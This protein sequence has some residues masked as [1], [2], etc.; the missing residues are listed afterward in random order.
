[1]ENTQCGCFGKHYANG[2]C[3]WHYDAIWRMDNLE[4]VRETVR[5]N[6]KIFYKRHRLEEL[7]RNRLYFQNHRKE[8]AEYRKKYCST[9]KGK[10]ITRKI[11]Q[12]WRKNNVKRRIAHYLAHENIKGYKPCVICGKLPTHKH[13]P[14]INKPLE[15]IYLCPLHHKQA[16]MQLNQMI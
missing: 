9:P 5:K 16:D 10:E 2:F 8:K 12:N 14:D 15:I 6:G 4:K 3:K 13:H 7:E 1:M 11:Q